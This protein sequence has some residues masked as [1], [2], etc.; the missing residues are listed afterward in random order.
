M[1]PVT[2][3]TTVNINVDKEGA[4]AIAAAIQSTGSQ[5][6]LGAA[7]GGLAAAA[8]KS[9]VGYALPPIQ[10]VGLIGVAEV[11]GGLVH[12]GATAINRELSK[13]M[14]SGNSS[15]NVAATPTH[16]SNTP[17]PLIPS[18]ELEKGVVANSPLDPSNLFP[19]SFD[20]NNTVDVI[21]FSLIFI[22]III[23]CLLILL[24]FSFVKSILN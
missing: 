5:I 1:D 10:K 11:V 7:I 21:F 14:T 17:S 3:S 12:C 9:I 18:S 22:N 13:S 6:G 19:S 24:S 8:S 16:S 15:N 20:F 2:V 23:F 4:E